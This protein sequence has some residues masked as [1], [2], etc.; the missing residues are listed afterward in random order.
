MDHL[1]KYKDIKLVFVPDKKDPSPLKAKVYRQDQYDLIKS[2]RGKV[3]KLIINLKISN[4]G[5]NKKNRD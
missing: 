1:I 2:L 4:N 3:F 5:N